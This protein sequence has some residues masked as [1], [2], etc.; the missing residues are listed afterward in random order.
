[1]A[2]TTCP[3]CSTHIHELINC[4]G[5]KVIGQGD[6]LAHEYAWNTDDINHG[7]SRMTH[8]TYCTQILYLTHSFGRKRDDER[9]QRHFTEMLLPPLLIGEVR[10]R[11]WNG[12]NDTLHEK[13]QLPQ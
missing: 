3:Q 13:N 11:P 10:R 7:L 5:T 6:E 12:I 2:K 9:D 1:M 8:T 4:H